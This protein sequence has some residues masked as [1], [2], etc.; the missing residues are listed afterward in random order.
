MI[1]KYILI[2]LLLFTSCSDKLYI[3]YCKKPLPSSIYVYDYH[4]NMH[5][6]YI[7]MN[8]LDID[9][10]HLVGDTTHFNYIYR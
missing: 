3:V 1:K 2:L 4:Y 7:P 6:P 10:V 5:I 8:Q 9:S